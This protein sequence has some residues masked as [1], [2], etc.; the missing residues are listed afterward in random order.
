MNGAREVTPI[1]AIK[2]GQEQNKPG[3]RLRLEAGT[4]AQESLIPF[5]FS[6]GLHQLLT[7]RS[8]QGKH[9]TG[10]DQRDSLGKAG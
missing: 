5:L 3:I 7:C 4:K 8:L 9:V 10:E 6:V 1:K 2:P